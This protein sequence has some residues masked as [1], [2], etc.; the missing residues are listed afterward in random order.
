VHAV[1]VSEPVTC[2][3]CGKVVA[4]RPLGWSLQVC[5]PAEQGEKR[6]LCEDCTRQHVRAIEGR[7]DDSW[8]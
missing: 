3:A 8:W 6:W 7:L 5:G 2:W 4:E 1:V